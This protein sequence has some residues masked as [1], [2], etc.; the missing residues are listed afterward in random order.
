MSKVSFTM[1]KSDIHNDPKIRSLP[2]ND[3]ARLAYFVMTTSPSTTYTGCFFYPIEHLCSHSGIDREIAT[4]SMERLVGVGLVEYDHQT[5]F[6]RLVGW[7]YKFFVP[8]NADHLSKVVKSFLRDPLP[9][10]AMSARAVSE[11]IVGSLVKAKSFDRNKPHT[12]NYYA[13]LQT[14]VTDAEIL[15]PDLLAAIRAEIVLNAP[16]VRDDFAI[17]HP[18]SGALKLDKCIGEHGGPTVQ[19]PSP[20]HVGTVP[21]QK[22]E[23]KKDKNTGAPLPATVTPLRPL[24]STLNSEIARK[25]RGQ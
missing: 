24:A 8:A 16:E 22:K 7:F 11:F 9:R 25:A 6:V 14:C 19:T 4:S 12:A 2:K 23:N 18:E 17:L 10:N 15:Y 5:E 3:V 20:D 13:H 1:V 21:T